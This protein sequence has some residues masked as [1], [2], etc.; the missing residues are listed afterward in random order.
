MAKTILPR[1]PKPFNRGGGPSYR[2]SEFSEAL[3]D[4]TTFEG[5]SVKGE[6]VLTVQRGEVL[7]RDAGVNGPM[8]APGGARY[9]PG[10]GRCWLTPIPATRQSDSA[11]I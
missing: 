4:H 6:P 3:A 11:I 5:K 8:G 2:T 10:R 1:E 7:V 9:A